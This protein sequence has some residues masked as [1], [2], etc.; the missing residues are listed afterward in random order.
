MEDAESCE[1]LDLKDAVYYWKHLYYEVNKELEEQL[2]A[3]REYEIEMEL[4]AERTKQ[5][6]L[7]SRMEID[8]LKKEL[9]ISKHRLF[10]RDNESFK[11]ISDLQAELKS[12]SP[13]Y[14]KVKSQLRELEQSY[15]DLER[16]ERVTQAYLTDLR[17]ELENSLE[18]NALLELENGNLLLELQRF[19]DSVDN[20]GYL[21]KQRSI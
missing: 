16:Q 3:S 20:S 19:K 12:A 21:K 1:P 17:G 2:A 11:V 6:L 13:N 9:E 10:E 15:D 5:Q 14:Q 8:N 4:A 7:A 18:K